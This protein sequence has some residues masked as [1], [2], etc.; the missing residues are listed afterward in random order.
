[1]RLERRPPG[2]VGLLRLVRETEA[3]EAALV[4]NAVVQV[5]EGVEVH[6]GELDVVQAALV[7][8]GGAEPAPAVRESLPASEAADQAAAAVPEQAAEAAADVD[9]VT[10]AGLDSD[11]AKVFPVTNRDENVLAPAG[12]GQAGPTEGP[13]VPESLASAGEQ[14]VE[15]V[16]EGLKEESENEDGAWEGSHPKS[17]DK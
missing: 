4:E 1:M 8:V 10:K 15:P 17:F 6:G 7:G 3:W 12:S 11:E 14:E 2:F 16:P 13:G 5:G 9:G